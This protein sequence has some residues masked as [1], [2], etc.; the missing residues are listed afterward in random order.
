MIGWERNASDGTIL[1][2][3]LGDHVVGSV[4]GDVTNKDGIAWCT[5]LVTKAFGTV[6][7]A[8]FEASV[9]I[10]ARSAEVNIH[11]TSVKFDAIL[12]FQSSFS[13]YGSSKFDITKS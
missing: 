4:E 2:E 1:L 11:G 5:L 3:S 6:V 12:S 13:S 10:A 8:L 7:G 9:V